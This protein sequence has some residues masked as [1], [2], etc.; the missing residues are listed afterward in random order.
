MGHVAGTGRTE[1]SYKIVIGKYEWKR[2][3]VTTYT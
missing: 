2:K 1:R 3:R